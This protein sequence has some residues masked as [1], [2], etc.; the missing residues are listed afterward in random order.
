M[1]GVPHQSVPVTGEYHQAFIDKRLSLIIILH[2]TNGRHYIEQQK[3]TGKGK[4][5]LIGIWQD[6]IQILIQAVAIGFDFLLSTCS[7]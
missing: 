7:C 3:I 1:N 2:E 4:D 6:S 5:G